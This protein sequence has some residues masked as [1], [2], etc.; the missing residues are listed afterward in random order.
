MRLS[1]KGRYALEALVVLC[2]KSDDKKNISLTEICKET[3]LSQRYLDQLFRDLKN[4]GIVI[5]KKG[6]TG[7]YHLAKPPA[8][9]T[10]G[11]ILRSVEGSLTPVKCIDNEYCDRV[12]S[13]ITRDLW[14][15]VY[16]ELN[17][18]VDNITLNSLVDKYKRKL[19][20]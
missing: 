12:D 15:D 9:I 14:I 6:K 7:G 11:D 1:T 19:A 16:T 3:S 17:S 2:L 13:C 18:V 5:S 8:D 10:V 20:G 4:H